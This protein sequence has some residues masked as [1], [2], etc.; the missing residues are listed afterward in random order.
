[1]AHPLQILFILPSTRRAEDLVAILRHGGLRFEYVVVDQDFT[2]DEI[3]GWSWDVVIADPSPLDGIIE[4]I[5]GRLSLRRIRPP[6]ILF[7]ESVALYQAVDFMRLGAAD[8]LLHEDSQRLPE[9]VS[10]AI[11]RGVAHRALNRDD[12]F[13]QFAQFS[14]EKAV[15]AV[16]WLDSLGRFFFVNEAAGIMLGYARR[17]LTMMSVF[18]VNPTMFC[19]SWAMLWDELRVNRNI[20]V[21]TSVLARDGRLIP[22]EMTLNLLVLDGQEYMT[23][24]ARDVTPR[25]K[26]ERALAAEESRYRSLFEEC[27]ISLW[28]EDLSDVKLFFDEL[29]TKGV[30]DF[31]AHFATNTQDLL[32]C[33][34]RVK[35][36][37]VNK[38]TVELLEARSKAELLAGL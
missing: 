28:E 11:D 20:V 37:N 3:I 22:V 17:E 23:A 14:I 12:R 5:L 24:F 18:D 32:E 35:I 26:V 38:A 19:E 13:L 4:D 7:A 6:V 29:R 31:K 36:I 34:R 15:E 1:M 8:F 27:P 9:V 25:K 33:I 2:L 10:R 21:E 30:T 16:F